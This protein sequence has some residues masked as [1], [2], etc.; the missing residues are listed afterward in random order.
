MDHT[1]N[2]QL[3]AAAIRHPACG[4]W[5]TGHTR[6]HCPVCHRTFSV[7]S[8]ADKHRK[9]AYGGGRHCVDPQTVGLVAVQKP[10]G[11]LWQNPGSD[12]TWFSPAT[13]DES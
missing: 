3:P 4:Q 8:A 11:T 12:T 9:G 2:P 6:S 5:W 10:Y 13:G 7:D 1:N